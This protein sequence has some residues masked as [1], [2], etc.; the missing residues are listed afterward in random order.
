MVYDC[1]ECVKFIGQSGNCRLHRKNCLAF[2]KEP[3]GKRI[4][5]FIAVEINPDA[6]TKRIQP[7]ESV[8]LV[9]ET[10][11]EAEAEVRRIEYIDFCKWEIGMRVCLFENDLKYLCQYRDKRNLFRV[12]LGG[13]NGNGG[14]TDSI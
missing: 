6:E 2:E 8:S 1:E 3:R 11:Y 4:L 13:R 7:G 14:E 10:G 5:H 12:I 9:G